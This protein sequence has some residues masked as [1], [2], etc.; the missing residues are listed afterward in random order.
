M[1]LKSGDK[2]RFLNEKIEGTISRLLSNE[3]VEVTDSHGFTHITD[4]KHLVL[5]E[6]V[7]DESHIESEKNREE[8]A[9]PKAAPLKK[10]SSQLIQSLEIDNTIY[11]AI[12]LMNEK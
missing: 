6:L 1:K 9:S 4:E 3:K 5:V 12:R 10:S 8:P 11:A 7:L 2:V